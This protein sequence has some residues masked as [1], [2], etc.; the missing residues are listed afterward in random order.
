LITFTWQTFPSLAWFGA[1]L[2]RPIAKRRMNVI[3]V[4]FASVKLRR[5]GE[6]DRWH[7]RKRV[8]KNPKWDG[9]SPL[10]YWRFE[11]FEHAAR[12]AQH[13]FIEM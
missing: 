5:R 3:S 9:F 10:F 6:A 13:D 4:G 8:S 7:D 12:F 11:K 2:W 1:Y